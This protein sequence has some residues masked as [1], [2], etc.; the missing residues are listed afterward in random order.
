[1]AEEQE[2]SKSEP[3]LKKLFLPLILIL[4]VCRIFLFN[5]AFPL[6]NNVDEYAHFDIVYKYSA[7]QFPDSA[8]ENYSHGSSELIILYGTPE[9]FTKPEKLQDK[10]ISPALWR[11]P[12]IRKT[13]QFNNILSKYKGKINHE[14]GSFPLYYLTAGLWYSVGE[15]IGLQDGQLLYWLRFLNILIAAAFVW[16][17]WLFAKMVFSEN[18]YFQIALPLLA[19]F[20]PQD[21]FYAINS[22]ALSLLF[23][24]WSFYLL[25][26]LHYDNKSCL[27]YCLTGFVVSAAILT[28]IS[29][30]T[31][32]LLFAII[33][34]LKIRNDLK[35]GILKKNL[36]HLCLLILSASAPVGVL[37]IRNYFVFGDFSATGAKI[38]H[39]GWTVKPLRDFFNHPLLTIQG[40]GH[41][42]S[43]LTVTFWRGE[44]VWYFKRIASR[45]SDLFYIISSAI[46]LLSSGLGIFINR[47]KRIGHHNFILMICFATVAASVFFLAF[48]SMRYDFGKCFYPSRELPYFTSG[49]LLSGVLL[50]FMIIYL[51]GLAN[52]IKWLKLRINPLILVILI[53]II[54]TSVEVALSLKVFSSTYNWFHL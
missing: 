7:G 40:C 12:D 15:T 17:C 39:L 19:A 13:P 31:I 34:I 27:Y 37:L 46:L 52:I 21:L 38:E 45:G 14:S 3:G 10:G 36:P 41:F 16:I 5:A 6:F 8:L 33:V 53:A 20:W 25:V 1:M 30:I 24:A 50:P 51:D 54:I 44:F 2:L 49:R 48:L 43:E 47:K 42:L 4:A 28:K 29:N 23:Y 35:D 9:Y 22:D 26:Q 11:Y 32:A 18:K